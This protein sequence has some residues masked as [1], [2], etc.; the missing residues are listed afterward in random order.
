MELVVKNHLP[1]QETETQVGSQGRSLEEGMATHFSILAWK[2]PWTEELGSL[3]STMGSQ[4]T[5]HDGA[6]EHCQTERSQRWEAVGNYDCQLV[7]PSEIHRDM[8]LVNQ[9]CRGESFWKVFT[10]DIGAQRVTLEAW[11]WTQS[12]N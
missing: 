4:R 1:M 11:Y 8:V 3:Q 10:P 9:S 6:T 12:I 2:I 5:G 7:T